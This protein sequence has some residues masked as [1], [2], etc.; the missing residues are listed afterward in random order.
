MIGFPSQG[1]GNLQGIFEIVHRK[2]HGD[3]HLG[4]AHR[5]HIHQSHKPG[6]K[7]PSVILQQI[8][9]IRDGVPRDTGLATILS[10]AQ[11][12][13]ATGY[14]WPSR[15]GDV[16]KNIRI[17]K[18]PHNRLNLTQIFRPQ[19]FTKWIMRTELLAKSTTPN[20]TIDD[21][22]LLQGLTP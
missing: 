15:Q 2:F 3:F 16:Q 9:T 17:N 12:G 4:F 7:L 21:R 18:N 20:H 5:C 1:T 22:L 13:G 14:E 10:P 6:Q 19:T 11:D 8:R